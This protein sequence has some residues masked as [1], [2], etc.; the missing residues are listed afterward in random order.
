L[1]RESH[2]NIIPRW[3]P[4]RSFAVEDLRFLSPPSPIARAFGSPFNT[5]TIQ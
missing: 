4:K 3:R 2:G 5:Q 1:H